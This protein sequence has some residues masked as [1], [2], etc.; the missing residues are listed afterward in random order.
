M[1]YINQEINNITIA[2]NHTDNYTNYTLKLEN[3]ITNT[4]VEFTVENLSINYGTYVFEIDATDL[5]IG[6]YE[7]SVNTIDGSTNDTGLLMIGNYTIPITEY[8][9]NINNIKQYGE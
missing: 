3:V 5:D 2:R 9:N 8:N 7:Y 1:V 6:E 4:T